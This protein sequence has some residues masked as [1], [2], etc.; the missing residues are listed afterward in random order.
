MVKNS[1]Y[2]RTENRTVGEVRK[3][4]VDEYLE[5]TS[6]FRNE[7]CWSPHQQMRF[8]ESLLMGI[9]PQVLYLVECESGRVTVLDGLQRLTALWCYVNSEDFEKLSLIEKQRVEDIQLTFFVLP[10]G[11]ARE[12]ANDIYKRLNP[13]F[14]FNSDNL[15]VKLLTY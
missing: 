12:K 14:Y 15:D 4:I 1:F 6:H 11:V 8:I 5:L 3:R 2:F 9:P 7:F 13:D 10:Y